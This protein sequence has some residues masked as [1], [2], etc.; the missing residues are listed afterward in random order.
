V[1]YKLLHENSGQRTFAVVLSTGEEVLSSLNDFLK[2]EDV[3]AA[4]LTAI[5]ALSELVLMYF[6][7]EKKRVPETTGEGAGRSRFPDWR[8]GGRP[9]WGA[10]AAYT[11]RGRNPRWQRRS[12]T[13]RRSARAADP[14]K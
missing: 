3:H 9:G 10:H 14:S 8:R 13:S 6:D 12:W 7:W 1:D 11:Y 5:G 2:R 4:Q